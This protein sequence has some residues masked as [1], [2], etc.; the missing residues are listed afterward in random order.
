MKA[1]GD[2]VTS[3]HGDKGSNIEGASGQVGTLARE[4]ARTRR[5][6]APTHRMN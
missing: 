1:R 2:K 5:S 4:D 3:G 6:R